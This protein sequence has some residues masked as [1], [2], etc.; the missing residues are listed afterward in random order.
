MCDRSYR[1]AEEFDFKKLAG[2][3]AGVIEKMQQ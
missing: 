3:M 1:T 2:D